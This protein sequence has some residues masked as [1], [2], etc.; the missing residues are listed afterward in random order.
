M[1]TQFPFP[2][3]IRNAFHPSSGAHSSG[4]FSP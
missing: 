2:D 4:I 3:A 1:Q